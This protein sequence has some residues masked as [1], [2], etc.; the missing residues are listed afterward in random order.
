MLQGR[1]DLYRSDRHLDGLA[2]AE[3]GRAS[4]HTRS[5][6]PCRRHMLY[7]LGSASPSSPPSST[8]RRPIWSSSSP[9][10]RCLRRCLSWI[11]LK[12]RPRPATFVA[13]PVDGRWRSDHRRRRLG[14]GNIFGDLMALCSAFFDRLGHH[15]FPRQRQG[16]GLHLACRRHLAVGRR[17]VHGLGRQAFNVEA[18]WWIIFNGAVIMPISFFCLATGPRYISGPEVAMFY[19]LETVLAPV[20]VWMIF[21]ETPSTQQ[22]DRRRHPDRRARRPLTVAAA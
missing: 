21:A 3:Q 4:A 14:S 16:H 13:M 8:P 18:P 1:N 17:R 2:P 7:G 22:P 15:D 12:E 20:W 11:F 5:R 6:G 10:P 9:S 19:L